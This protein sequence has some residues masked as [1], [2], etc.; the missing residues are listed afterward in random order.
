MERV[1]TNGADILIREQQLL[2][3]FQ[4]DSEPRTP[5]SR[6]PPASQFIPAQLGLPTIVAKCLA[7]RAR[8]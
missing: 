8:I 7:E 1:S 2:F 3:R 4:P 6:A 5:T